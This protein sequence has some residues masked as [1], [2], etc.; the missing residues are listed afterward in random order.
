M[1]YKYKRAS[2]PTI[3]SVLLFLALPFCVHSAPVDYQKT[4]K[5]IDIT[6]KNFKFIPSKIQ[7]P[8]G[9]T[10]TLKFTNN[11]TVTHAFMAGKNLT[12]DLEGYKNGLFSGVKVIKKTQSSAITRTYGSKSL[13]LEVPAGET[14]TLTFTM[15]ESKK[16]TYRFGC[17]K[18]TGGTEHYTLG[19]KGSIK[20]E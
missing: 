1:L 14:A 19:M 13:M 11:G 20:I 15:P 6:M 17:F 12:D 9:K 16:G 3:L 18:T 8:A 5:E 4:G 2:F 7:I 10:V